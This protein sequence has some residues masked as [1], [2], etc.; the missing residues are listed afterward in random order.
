MLHLSGTKPKGREP[1]LEEAQPDH[2]IKSAIAITK[3]LL[4][5]D[6]LTKKKKNNSNKEK[7]D[8]F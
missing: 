4:G 5:H 3:L 7:C 2:A 6:I 1:M 8:Y